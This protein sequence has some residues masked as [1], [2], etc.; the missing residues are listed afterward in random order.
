M[1]CPKDEKAASATVLQALHCLVTLAEGMQGSYLQLTGIFL[2]IS[3]LAAEIY[4][5]R[6]TTLAG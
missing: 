2:A 4:Q 1:A 5:H 3:C 6:S